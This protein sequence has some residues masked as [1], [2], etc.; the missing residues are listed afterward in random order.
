VDTHWIGGEP[1]K[2]EV[3]GWASWSRRKGILALRNPKDEPGRIALDL[4][5]VFELPPGV[6]QQYSLKSPWK[7]DVATEPV[8]LSAGQA[9]TFALQPFEVLVF[10]ATPQ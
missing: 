7:D 2:G 3:Y 5:Q 8:T 6:P 4:G 9:H 1:A 10:D